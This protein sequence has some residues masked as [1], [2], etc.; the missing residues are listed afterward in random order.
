VAALTKR[1]KPITVG[2]LFRALLKYEQARAQAQDAQPPPAF[3]A[4]LS[5][6]LQL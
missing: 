3:L 1:L 5:Q 4:W 6:H 2:K